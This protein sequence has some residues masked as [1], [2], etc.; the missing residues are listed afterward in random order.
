MSL[1][2]SSAVSLKPS[3]RPGLIVTFVYVQTL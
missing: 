1:D 2:K 3:D